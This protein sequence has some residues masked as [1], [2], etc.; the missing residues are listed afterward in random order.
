M[1]LEPSISKAE[2]FLADILK[3]RK[4][5]SPEYGGNVMPAIE[6][7]RR[8]KSTED[9]RAYQDALELML[10]HH[11][12]EIRNYGVTLCLGFFVFRSVNTA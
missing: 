7:F 9:I 10:K 5:A 1:S 2:I 6:L 11:N 4:Q 8:L 3:S 12:E